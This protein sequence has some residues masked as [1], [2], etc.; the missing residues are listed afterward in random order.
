MSKHI[1]VMEDEAINYLNLNESSIVIDA[2][3]GGA[4]HSSSILRQIKRGFLYA[5]DEDSEVIEDAIK[6]LSSYGSNF[7]IINRNFRFMKEEVK[8]EV[9]AI[10]FDLGTSSMQLDSKERGFNYHYDSPLDM[11]MNK[12][13]SLTGKD[14]VNNYTEEELT[15][16][17][18][19]YTDEKYYK[20]IIKNI[21]G[22]RE[23]K[24]I[25]RTS[26]LVD[27]VK[28]S[29]PYSYSNKTHPAR[30]TFMALRIEVNDELGSLKEGLESAFDLLKRG[31]RL[32]VISF[33]K[34]EDKIVKNFIKEKT[35]E[36]EVTKGD[37]FVKD[38]FKRKAKRITKK[39]VSKEEILNNFRSRSAVLRVIE[40]E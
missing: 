36:D 30:K 8:E 7:K 18:R 4:G 15:N 16:I 1:P 32:A 12:N 19:K 17:F 2:T 20:S 23:T 34:E 3:L 5:F 37:P 27:I 29:V 24:E 33:S 28:N 22:Y 6:K 31:G 38:T 35:K 11:R 13:S 25:T 39:K 9:D 10:L 40:K 26:E 21:I 14:I